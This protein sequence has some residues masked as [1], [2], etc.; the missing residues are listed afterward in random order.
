MPYRRT[1]DG[2]ALRAWYNANERSKK[3][4]YEYSAGDVVSKEDFL[5]MVKG[6]EAYN[7]LYKDWEDSNFSYGLTPTLDRKDSNKG[8]S[9]DNIQFLTF[10]DNA[11]KNHDR[12]SFKDLSEEKYKK[13]GIK[14]G[15]KLNRLLYGELQDSIK[16]ASAQDIDEMVEINAALSELSN[17]AASIRK[18]VHPMEMVKAANFVLSEENYLK[19]HNTKLARAISSRFDYIDRFVNLGTYNEAEG[20]FIK[21]SFLCIAESNISDKEKT[22][23]LIIN[24][25]SFMSTNRNDYDIFVT[26]DEIEKNASDEAVGDEQGGTEILTDE[27]MNMIREEM[28]DDVADGLLENQENVYNALPLPHKQRIQEMYNSINAPGSK[29]ASL[30]LTMGLTGLGAAAGR[31]GIIKGDKINPDRTDGMVMGAT[32][33]NLAGQLVSDYYNGKSDQEVV[34]DANGFPLL[35]LEGA[36]FGSLLGY[37]SARD[38]KLRNTV[39]GAGMGAAATE[40]LKRMM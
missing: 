35:G 14:L 22:A 7:K 27:V 31:A 11:R 23:L 32:G 13:G 9:A 36:T 34:T 33:G 18:D 8:Y 3:D 37:N 2:R 24:D 17:K 28:G 29:T 26:N 19:I 30:L 4:G 39:I 38:N 15:S 10:A 1:I 21:L 6:S 25:K 5:N 20:N 16:E 12:D 40:A